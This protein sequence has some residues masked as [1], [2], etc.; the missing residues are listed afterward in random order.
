MN[1]EHILIKK[2]DGVAIITINRHER[3][4]ALAAQTIE[5]LDHAF[6]ELENDTD[7]GAVVITGAGDKAFCAG[8]DIEEGFKPQTPNPEPRTTSYDISYFVRR[9]QEVFQKIEKFPLPVIA[10]VN[11]YALG[12]GFELMMSCDI[13]IAAE[14]AALGQPEV[15]RGIMPGWGGTQM[16]PRRVGKYRAM[17]LLLL[18]GRIKARDAEAMGLVN[19]VVPKGEELFT[20]MEIAKRFARAPRD[21]VR[22]I[23][24]AVIR[25]SAMSIDEGLKIELENF[26]KTFK[27]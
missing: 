3:R 18:G 11:G 12:G 17:E 19:K 27:K 8:A 22:L 15:N 2:E 21:S 1:Y 7:L 14:N 13:V 6:T 9:G 20:A 24:D 16:L 23:K 26:L 10:A 5:E 4:N 25:G